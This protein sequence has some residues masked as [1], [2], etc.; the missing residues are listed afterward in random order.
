MIN[1][2]A[3]ANLIVP[4]LIRV[5]MVLVLGYLVWRIIG[6]GAPRV[7]QLLLTRELAARDEE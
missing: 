5:G 6:G 7:I 1:W 3:I 4:H 2:T